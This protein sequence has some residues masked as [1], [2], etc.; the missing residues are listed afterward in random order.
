MQT[1][2]LDTPPEQQA[3][4]ERALTYT[5]PE[6]TFTTVTAYQNQQ[7]SIGKFNYQPPSPI[8]LQQRR[9]LLH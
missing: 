5:F 7:V 1:K 3:R 8:T 2:D 9:S 4:V 6:T